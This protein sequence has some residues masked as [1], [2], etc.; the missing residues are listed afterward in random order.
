MRSPRRGTETSKRRE[1]LIDAVLC[2]WTAAL[3]W[4][5]GGAR[6]QALG[7]APDADGIQP[8]MIAPCR[9]EQRVAVRAAGR[10]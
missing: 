2:A 9:P 3:W 4:R 10:P 5:F 6:C 8:A 7:L 1:D